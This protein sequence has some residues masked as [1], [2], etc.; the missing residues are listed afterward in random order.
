MRCGARRKNA[1][2]KTMTFRR[3][4]AREFFSGVSFGKME[5]LTPH[6]LQAHCQTNCK[7][8]K[9]WKR[10]WPWK[11]DKFLYMFE[12]HRRLKLGARGE[13]STR[14]YRAGWLV[15]PSHFIGSNCVLMFRRFCPCC[16]SMSKIVGKDNQHECSSKFLTWTNNFMEYNTAPPENIH[17]TCP[18]IHTI[19]Q[20]TDH[21]KF[22]SACH[23]SNA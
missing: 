1:F 11:C 2:W 22:E 19:Q 8:V 18:G 17:D 16:E 10:A 21:C 9:T 23:K 15:E 20:N 3:Y 12:H 7:Q 13:P 6:R 4:Q 14:V 5:L